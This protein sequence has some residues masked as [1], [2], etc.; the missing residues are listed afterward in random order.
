VFTS[1]VLERRRGEREQARAVVGAVERHDSGPSGCEQRRSQ[2][3]LDRV[4][5]RDAELGRP[6]E[7]LAQPHRHLGVGKVAER[8]HDLLLAPRLED[9]RVAVA[10]RGDAEAAG[11]VEQLA[12]V[13]ERDAAAF[14]TAPDHGRKRPNVSAAT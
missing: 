8:V 12:A 7:R 10:E 9:A 5:S 2:R 14:G 1:T 3:D 13:R 6:R 11:Q 4:L